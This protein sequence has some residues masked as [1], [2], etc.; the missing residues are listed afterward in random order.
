MFYI[1]VLLVLCNI[2]YVQYFPSF[3]LEGNDLSNQH[4]SYINKGFFL[5]CFLYLILSQNY[6]IW[7][8]TLKILYFLISGNVM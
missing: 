7:Q 6:W 1:I 4:M 5:A 8:V 2:P 3:Y